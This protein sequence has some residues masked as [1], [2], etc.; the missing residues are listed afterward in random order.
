MFT[1][2]KTGDFTGVAVTAHGLPKQ[3]A[4]NTTIRCG[5]QSRIVYDVV[6]VFTVDYQDDVACVTLESV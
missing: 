2:L 3:L 5:G 4:A 6:L 1:V